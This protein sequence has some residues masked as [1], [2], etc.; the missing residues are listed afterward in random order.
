MSQEVKDFQFATAK[1][2]LH[3][4][5]DL[6]HRRV[7][8][9]DEVGLGKTFVAKQV[10]DLVRE[11]HKEKKDDFF[12]V[13][14][15]CSNVN[16]ADQNIEKLGVENRMNISE[17]RLSMQHLYIKLAE[18]SISEQR[19]K[20]K[21]P[22]SIIP[23]TPST[24]FRFYS[25]QGTANERA[26]ICNILCSLRQ[27]S[28]YKEA[29]E[30]FLSCGVK[31]WQELI[32]SYSE[33]IKLCGPEYLD[34]MQSKLQLKLTD[35][36]ISQIINYAQNGCEYRQRSIIINT[37]RRIFAEISIDMLDPDLVIMDEF[38]RF[39]SLLEQGDD[40]QSMLA[41]KFFDI[42]RS[43]TKI[44]LLSATP[45]KPYSTLEDLNVDGN[46]EHYHDFM[47]VMDFL[48]ATK[49]KTNHFKLIWKCYSDALKGTDI[50][51]LEPLV[52][53]KNVAEKELYSVM[54][55]TERFN[56]GIIDD[57][58]VCDVQV[59]AEDILAYAE[60]QNLID[61][62]SE[63]SP[64]ARLS[65]LP[66]EYVKSSP[67]LLSFMDKYELKKQIVSV[68][69]KSDALS[70]CRTDS[71]LLS[72]YNINNYR[73]INMANGRLKYL[74]DLVFG[75]RH[76]KR[77]QYLLWIPAS[78]PYYRAGGL[79]ETI[80]ARKFSKII[81]FSS[82]E[83]VPRMISVMMSFYSE[84]YTFG[85]LKKHEPYLRYFS[86]KKNRY[87]ENRL[88]A[89]NLLEYPCKT[90]AS[91]YSPSEF[92]GEQLSQ[93]R[94]V[95]SKKVKEKLEQNK[96]IRQLSKHGRNKASLILSLMKILN[97]ENPEN[98]NELYIPTNTIEV[99]T[100]I[101]IASPAVCA[102]RQ[103][104]IEEDSQMVAK[105]VV[106]IFNKPESAAIIDLLYNKKND[107]DYY[108]S[109]LDY[110]VKGNLQAVLDE[111]AHMAQTN[112][113]GETVSDAVISTSNLSI[114][115][116][117][118]L[119]KEEKKLQMRCHFAIPFIDKTITD[120]AIM[121]TTNIR[122]AFN[123]PFRPFILSTTSIGQ[124]G[125]DFHWYARKIV[126]WNLPS[127]PIDLEQRE[128]RINR[129]KCLAIRRNISKLYANNIFHTW[130]ELFEI[131]HEK[132]KKNH[133]D[134]VPY[135][136]L[137]IS[138]LTDEQHL[139][140]EYIE[141]I[142]PLYP[143]SRDRYKYEHLI[144]VLSLYRMTLGQPR[145]EELLNLLKNM[146]LSE[147]QLQELTMD[148]CPYNKEHKHSGIE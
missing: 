63:E 84:L 131:A 27:F 73:P 80:E 81:L 145:Q 85:E 61:Y 47:K 92:Y 79:F 35:D 43:N 1:R 126:H 106:S 127:N 90:L 132:L 22:E 97:G 66:M 91:L 144:K 56:S 68:L 12:K 64:K 46:D 104:G 82:W 133:S 20:G 15:I 71:L 3:I 57:S 9:A 65:N 33:K 137:P 55:R 124:E 8:L 93:I 121:R 77:T 138:E 114:D 143:L 52:A 62:L 89:D 101:A 25:A 10:I 37:L 87:G 54:C 83:M 26:L 5:K 2:I 120:K 72:K 134:I 28:F 140:L 123:S 58:R 115:T 112:K 36:T 98:L 136:C 139:K 42:K 13:V 40:E 51:D 118:S 41:N 117:D 105:A 100:D 142:V 44:L 86:V 21:M 50:I 60:C 4:Y 148:L 39:N 141:R 29:I 11:W 95:I 108:E 129:Y 48:F 45:Y 119:G 99:M 78:N 53:T 130:D 122:K 34:E 128:G 6:G 147:T 102:Y 109:V 116:T 125:L 74:H 31:Y 146:H 75:S 18:K 24:S 70:V 38:Q 110:C 7:L 76:E 23:L 14:Y 103:S 19:E 59:L 88:R 16:I 17:S 49:D 135:W 113:L 30:K 107:D 32:N 69:Q 94:R 67:Y 111:F 96:I